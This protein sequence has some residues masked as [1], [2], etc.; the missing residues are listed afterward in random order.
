M[1]TLSNAA[2]AGMH[3]ITIRATD[4]CNASTDA[5][6]QVTVHQP[7]ALLFSDGFERGCQP[8]QL[9]ADSGLELTVPPNPAWGS[10]STNFGDV[11]CSVG[12]CA[13]GGINAAP[14][15]GAWYAW[16]GGVDGEETGR[17]TQSVTI[18]AGAPRHLNF[19]LRRGRV[20]A[21]LDAQLRVKVDGSSVRVFDEPAAAEPAYVARTVDLSAFTNGASHQIEFAYINPPSSGN[22]SFLVDDITLTCTA[23][24][25]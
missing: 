14:R 23:S 22:S 13:T 25:N 16:F 4:N 5:I 12:I 21:P 18:P 7:G 10:T 9:L 20:G 8:V 2:P 3:A 15:N 6:I 1:V 24:G 19:F 11:F 17:L